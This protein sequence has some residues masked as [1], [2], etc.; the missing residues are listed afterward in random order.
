MKCHNSVSVHC[1]EI[2]IL[3]SYDAAMGWSSVNLWVMFEEILGLL[4]GIIM[5]RGRDGVN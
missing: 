2:V 1:G 5:N 3:C 4:L